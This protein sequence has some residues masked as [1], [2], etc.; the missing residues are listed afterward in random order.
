MV[1]KLILETESYQIIIILILL[2]TAVFLT[3]YFHF[4]LG[5]STVFTHFFYFPIILAAI[6]WK[7]KGLVIPI[8]LS[9]L[10]ILS[11]FLAPKLSYP[12]YEDIIR[13][14]VFMA[15]GI[16]VVFLSENITEKYNKLLESQEKFQSIIDSAV[17]GIITT[18]MDSKIVLFNHSLK[19]IFGYDNDEIEGK[20][21]TMLM[22]DRYKQKFIDKLDK[23]NSTGNHELEGQTFD[24]YGLRNDGTEFP[25]EISI[26][27]WGPKSNKFTTS[28]IRDVTSRKKTEKMLKNSLDAKE[29]LLKEIHHRMKNNLMIISSL[30]N[31][32]SRY[33]KDEESK[34]IFKESQNRA[35]SMA[36]MHERLYQS[37]DLKSIDFGDYISTQANDIYHT[38]VMDTNLIKLN[39]D[40]DDLRLDINTSIPLGLIVNELVTN[41]LK[42][43]FPEGKSGEIGIIFHKQDENYILEIKDN[44]VGFS[45]DIDY[46][47]TDS[48]GLQLI[49]NLTDQIDGEIEFNTSS[50]TSFKIS[51]KEGTI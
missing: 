44:G 46:N 30:L 2:A 3:Y 7:R 42:H 10:L 28:I 14:F 33:I 9:I 6:W 31:L 32:Q 23:F 35:R 48:L 15:I 43:G 1:N 38:Y 22:P 20:H 36:L 51:F 19:N 41:S 25:F 21:V 4:I 16:V 24:S 17:D 8:F 27:T 12:L 37:A 18:D 50:G 39:I 47:N 34:N 45:E 11:Y 26:A 49:N 29:M 5:S 13:V 40:V